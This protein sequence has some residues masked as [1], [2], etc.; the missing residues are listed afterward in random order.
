MT[1]KSSTSESSNVETLVDVDCLHLGLR[2]EAQVLCTSCRPSSQ[3]D[4][5]HRFGL[6]RQPSFF[7]RSDTRRDETS[8]CSE[9]PSVS[10]FLRMKDFET[11]FF[12]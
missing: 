2:K 10:L 9:Q 8:L 7:R 4:A 3:V 11:Y 1:L 12:L 5:L 6:N